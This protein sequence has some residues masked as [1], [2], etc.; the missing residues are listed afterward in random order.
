[1]QQT[2][3]VG[4]GRTKITPTFGVPLAG[5]GNTHLRISDN[6]VSDL[7][8]TC[9]AIRDTQG[10]D[11]LLISQ[12]LVNSVLAKEVRPILASAT[13]IPQ[14]HIILASTHTHCGPDQTSSL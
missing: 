2:F 4:F 8:V 9:V 11:L 3:Q 6:V 5:Y 12:D 10:N 7:W 14:K 13:G 1:M